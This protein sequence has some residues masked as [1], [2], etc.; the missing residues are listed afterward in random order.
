MEYS[1]ATDLLWI[2]KN[3]LAV[4]VLNVDFADIKIMVLCI[5]LVE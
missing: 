1:S 5:Q 2:F 3:D 4:H